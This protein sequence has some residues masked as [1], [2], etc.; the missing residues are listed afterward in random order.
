MALSCK[1]PEIA[2]HFCVTDGYSAMSLC[3]KGE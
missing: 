2:M 1:V 3:V